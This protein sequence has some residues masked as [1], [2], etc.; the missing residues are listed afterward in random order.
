MRAGETSI[1]VVIMV[2]TMVANLV[3]IAI[4][5]KG[6]HIQII[7]AIPQAETFLQETGEEEEGALSP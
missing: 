3:K 5:K 6:Y 1:V 2:E 7:S 4:G